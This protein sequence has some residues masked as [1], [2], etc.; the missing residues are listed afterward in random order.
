[1]CVHDIF[2]SVL[3]TIKV[4]AEGERDDLLIY[5]QAI[6]EGSFCLSVF[7]SWHDYGWGFPDGAPLFNMGLP[8]FEVFLASA[9]ASWAESGSVLTHYLIEG[10]GCRM[11]NGAL[12]PVGTT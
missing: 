3:G 11:S 2:S 8:C 12:E 1:M 6:P 5:P 4:D 10:C 9:S 7:R